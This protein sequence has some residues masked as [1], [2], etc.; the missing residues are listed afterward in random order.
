MSED[1][2]HIQENKGFLSPVNRITKNVGDYQN[3]L[4]MLWREMLRSLPEES[5]RVFE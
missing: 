4:K 3:S 1:N 5:R 2:I